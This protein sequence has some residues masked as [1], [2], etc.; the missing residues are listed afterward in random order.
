MKEVRLFEVLDALNVQDEE[1]KTTNLKFCNSFLSA[2]YSAKQGGTRV[3]I[4]VPGNITA[5]LL[6]Q[7]VVP[8]LLIINHEE[9]KKMKSE[10]EK[11]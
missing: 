5:E 6:E 2:D 4:G 11:E 10:L 7:H 8:I 3:T 9:Y 1:N